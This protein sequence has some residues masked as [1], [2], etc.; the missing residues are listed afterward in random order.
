MNRAQ[1]Q[2]FVTGLTQGLDNVQAMALLSFNK[3]S[4]EQM[5]SFRLALSKASINVKVVK[6]T[7]A[8]R[9]FEGTPYKRKECKWTL[10]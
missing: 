1:K 8:K 2:E 6:N 3:L 4:V 9:A 7:L 10:N 5:T